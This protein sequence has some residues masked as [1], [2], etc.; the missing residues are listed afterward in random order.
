M[1]DVVVTKRCPTCGETKPVEDFGK[2]RARRDGVGSHCRPCTNARTAAYAAKHPE[3]AKARG[4]TWKMTH[5]GAA[6]AKQRRYRTAHPET[7]ALV[8]PHDRRIHPER[9]SARKKLHHALKTGRV[10]RPDGCEECSQPKRVQGHH[11]DYNQ[12]LNVRWLCSSCHK[13]VHLEVI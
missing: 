1:P 5:P 7:V 13:L 2:N 9:V 12:P 3:K 11:P 10:I 8:S 4:A 6:A